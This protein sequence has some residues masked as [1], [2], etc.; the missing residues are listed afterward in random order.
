MTF[1]IFHAKLQDLKDQF[2]KKK[3]FGKVEAHVHIIEFQK[4][5]LPH[6]YILIIIQEEYKILS[7][8]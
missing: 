2:F 3:I 5:G 4:R 7:E 1:R 8:D 6:A